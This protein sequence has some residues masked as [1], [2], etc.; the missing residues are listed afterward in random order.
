VKKK[1]H[2]ISVQRNKT[3]AGC[4]AI[5]NHYDIVAML[6]DAIAAASVHVAPVATTR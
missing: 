1:L 3:S 6:N 2:L 4:A 5:N